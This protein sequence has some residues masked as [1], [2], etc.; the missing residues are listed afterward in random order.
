MHR[1]PILLIFILLL[2]CGKSEEQVDEKLTLEQIGKKYAGKTTLV[3]LLPR[4]YELSEGQI[5]I[6]GVDTKEISLA[7]LR[8]QIALVSQHVTLFNDTISHNI[9]Y[10]SLENINHDDILRAAR[11]A[12]ALEFI[13][14]LPDGFET[15][16]G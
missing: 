1:K 11:A 4:F 14:Q 2:S 12:H 3:S 5:F 10:G 6:D 8:S 13:E 7:S 15:I 9:A 16:V